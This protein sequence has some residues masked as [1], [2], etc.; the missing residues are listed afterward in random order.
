MKK[1][2]IIALAT[3]LTLLC[4]CSKNEP[5]APLEPAEPARS[6][7]IADDESPENSEENSAESSTESTPNSVP[8]YP[9]QNTPSYTVTVT[10]YEHG[11]LVRTDFD[12]YDEHGNMIKASTKYGDYYFAYEYNADGT[13]RVKYG[14]RF[15]EEYEYENGLEVKCTNY[16]TDGEVYSVATHTYNEHGDTTSFSHS[17]GEFVS[18]YTYEY[19]Y[20]DENNPGLWTKEIGY[21]QWGEIDGISTRVLGE[22]GEVLSGTM[23]EENALLTYEYKYD[24]NGRVVEHHSTQTRNG[25]V[26]RERLILTKYDEQGRISLKEEYRLDGG[27]R[28]VSREEYNYTK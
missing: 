11:E 6:V 2:L 5:D 20:G 18:S 24:E 17:A 27:E 13:V 16:D 12:T 26:T 28:L 10:S 25:E 22:N 19:E 1:C 8:E 21:D 15:R 9:V 7:I 23:E 3:C 14:D 4:G